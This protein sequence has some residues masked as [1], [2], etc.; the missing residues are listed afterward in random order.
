MAGYQ[1]YLNAKKKINKIIAETIEQLDNQELKEKADNALTR[2]SERMLWNVLQDIGIS[3]V[4]LPLVVSLI[5]NGKDIQKII[6]SFFPPEGKI[7]PERTAYKIK[8]KYSKDYFNRVKKAFMKMAEDKAKYGEHIS[9]RNLAEMTVRYEEAL[10]NIENLKER[11]VNFV[12]STVHANCSK[13]C[14]KWQGKY[15]TL[16]NTYQLYDGKR[17]QP[18]SNATDIYYTTKAGKTYKNGHITGFNCRHKLI[19]YKPGMR[20]PKY[21]AK[22]VEK[23]RKIDTQMRLFEEEIRHQKDIA[24][25]FKGVDEQIYRTARMKAIQINKK[26]ID[27]ATKH[28]RPYYPNRVTI[29]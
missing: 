10:Q 25:M 9:L 19:E 6:N 18:L 21:S 23:E 11:G 12:V 27:F 17:F 7:P 14:A 3:K 20:I 26:Y 15:Y 8:N 4:S 1:N 13:R 28:K 5:V 2:F 24:L 29:F 16:D 22:L